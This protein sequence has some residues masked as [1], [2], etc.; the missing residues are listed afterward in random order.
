MQQVKTKQGVLTEGYSYLIA[1][2]LLIAREIKYNRED[3]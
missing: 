1:A 3:T 2:I